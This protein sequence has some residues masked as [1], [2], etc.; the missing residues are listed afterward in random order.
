MQSTGASHTQSRT[1]AQALTGAALGGAVLV[2]LFIFA[3]FRASNEESVLGWIVAGIILAWL[4]VAVY[5]AL[6]VS[7]QARAV[8]RNLA[9]V[10]AARRDAEKTMLNDKLSHSFQ[11]V[12]VQTRV[13]SEQLET[14][15]E[16]S[17]GMI[18]RAIDTINTTAR[19]GMDMVAQPES[20]HPNQ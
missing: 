2:A 19:N 13:I 1:T 10:S 6:I 7:R 5:F 12:L 18:N 14:P 8:H 4:G 9:G 20:G 11:I 15:G 3:I 17:A 16:D